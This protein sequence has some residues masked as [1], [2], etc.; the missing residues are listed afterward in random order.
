MPFFKKKRPAPG[1]DIEF[2]EFYDD[3]AESLN[4][5]LLAREWG[6]ARKILA[7]AGKDEFM[8][9]VQTAMGVDGVEQWIPEVIRQD[10]DDPLPRLVRGV[11]AIAWAWDVRG[12]GT[13]DTVSREA[14]PVFFQRLAL[15]EDS[16]D[17]A[18][19]RDPYLAEAW[20]YKIVL[21]RARQLP[22]EEEWRRFHRLIELDPSHYFGH[23]AMHEGLLPKWGG[24]W[25]GVF[26]FA[27]QRTAACPGTHVPHLISMAHLDARWV[28][29]HG[30]DAY[31]KRDEV[32]AEI[33]EAAYQS[34]WHDDH[35]T[36]I[37]TPNLWNSFAYTLTFGRYF[38]QACNLYDA[39][40]D[41]FVRLPLLWRGTDRFAEL[42]AWAREEAADPDY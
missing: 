3:D 4:E 29:G 38:K 10:P 33:L 37:L 1:A 36:T 9:Y 12:D 25:E 24:T 6:I 16:L 31:L 8:Y 5:A 18:L 41:D 14:W 42:R 11:R 2:P 13:A 32:S 40:G 22:A 39:I 17:E 28:D 19:D 7:G 26:R 27:R 20:H 35:E 21:G 15:A 30:G 23:K 34:V